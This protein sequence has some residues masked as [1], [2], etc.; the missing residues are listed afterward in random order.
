M[1]LQSAIKVLRLPATVAPFQMLRLE[2]AL[3][4]VD[5]SNWY[6]IKPGSLQIHVICSLAKIDVEQKTWAI[7]GVATEKIHKGRIVK[8]AR[9][10]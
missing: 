8:N 9:D 7:S 1:A 10:I 4:R 5:Q 3:W 2:E 6:F